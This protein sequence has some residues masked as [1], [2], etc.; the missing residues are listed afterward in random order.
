MFGDIL[1][2]FSSASANRRHLEAQGI[3]HIGRSVD[4][5]NAMS[6]NLFAAAFGAL[7][8]LWSAA[9]VDAPEFGTAEEARAMLD[10]AI[11][12]LKS[13]EATALSAFND[14]KRDS[15]FRRYRA[16][17]RDRISIG[18]IA[19]CLFVGCRIH[20]S[21]GEWRR[22]CN[23]PDETISELIAHPDRFTRGIAR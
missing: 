23:D 18:W 21:V 1:K 3:A 13:N 14:P 20:G 9:L 17:V 22:D 5:E 11:A 8:L 6:R 10:R 7:A 2:P 4:C 12:A 16:G 19:C 15:N